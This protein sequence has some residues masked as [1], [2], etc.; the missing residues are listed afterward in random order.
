MT[1]D[2][3]IKGYIT[4]F[5]DAEGSIFIR[6]KDGNY[7]LCTTITQSYY[8]ILL[9]IQ[10]MFG[11]SIETKPLQKKNNNEGFRKQEWALNFYSESATKILNYVNDY[12]IERK[13]RIE[14]GLE[15]IKNRI[16]CKGNQSKIGVSES[17]LNKR[18]FFYNEMKKLNEI[19]HD[20]NVSK[21]YY[22]EIKKQSISKEIT[23]GKQGILFGTIDD[24]YKNLGIKNEKL[25]NINTSNMTEDVLLG[26]LSGFFDGEG[27]VYINKAKES[28]GTCIEI[29][30]NNINILKLYSKKFKG[31]F[32]SRK[33]KRDNITYK[34]IQYRW[35]INSFDVMK[36]LSRIL[37]Y[38]IVK[39]KQI[40][41]AIEFEEWKSKIGKINNEEKRKKAEWYKL[42]LE[43][44]K[45]ETGE[46]CSINNNNNKYEDEDIKTGKQLTLTKLMEN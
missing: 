22:D 30:N 6:G 10:N 23:E 3:I 29:S 25:L 11:G 16:R 40:M 33:Q 35:K 9:R 46:I 14:L 43:E 17:E 18:E 27:C 39:N 34:D 32:S 15:Y 45:M 44:L 4:G 38:T 7:V 20:E 13:N 26:Y 2:D 5:F 28:Y 19:G 37:P 31:G 12:S 8:P 36:F 21:E 42:K 24:L 41:Y 1:Y